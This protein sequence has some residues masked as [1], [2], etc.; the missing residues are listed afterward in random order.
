LTLAAAPLGTAADPVK[1]LP[2]P[3]ARHTLYAIGQAPPAPT[4]PDLL[5]GRAALGTGNLVWHGGEVQHAPKVYLVFWGW[6][7]VDPAGAAPYLTSFFGGVGGNAWMAS[8]TQYTDATG[9]VGNPTG[10]LAGV[11]YD[12]TS[13]LAPSPDLSL[14]DSGL[15]VELEAIAAA[16]HFGYDVNADYIIATSS[17]HST[18]GFAANG[19]PY[20]AWHSWT[21]VDTGVHGVVPIAYT[22]LPYQTDAGASCGK[23]FVNAGAAGNLDGFSIVAGHE[24]AEVITD[25]HLDAWYDVT[26]YE[27][28]DKCAWNLGPGATARNIVIGGSNYAVQA[29]WSNSASACA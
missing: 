17:G 15:G 8:Q 11:W 22:N 19:G 29:L 24:Y 28:A 2:A 26:G 20:C 14:T 4:L 18:G 10:Q 13:P 12:D 6:H 23:S 7:G 9:A 3:V 16:A 5:P 27:N 1:D 25:P 21:G